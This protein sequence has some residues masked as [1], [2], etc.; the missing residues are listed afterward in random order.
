MGFVALTG[1][2]FILEMAGCQTEGTSTT[3][4]SGNVKTQGVYTTLALKD[5]GLNMPGAGYLTKSSFG[6]GET[7][8][9]VIVGYGDYNQQQLLTLE[10]IELGTGRSLLSQ[11]CYASYGKALVQ[12]LA[13]R[14][15]GDYKV[16]L[17]NGGKEWDAYQFTVVRTNRYGNTTDGPVN[18]GSSYGK[19][20]FSVSI[21]SNNGNGHFDNYDE[22]LIYTMVNAVTKDAEEVHSQL[23]AQRFPGKVVFECRLDFTG[24]LTEPK[25]EENT[26]DDE[27]STVLQQVLL[28]R[29]PYD[30]WPE[31]V[32]Q[33]MASDYRTLMITVSFD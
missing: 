5:V 22:Q 14:L 16:R 33:E 3:G 17:V 23:F 27:C 13:I 7:P 19:G 12:P 28:N 2:L 26:L 11:D 6:P 24:H 10:V 30:A 8:A 18:S 1:L 29:S 9:A 20:I 31:V 21:E 15:S 4:L 32:H 25:M